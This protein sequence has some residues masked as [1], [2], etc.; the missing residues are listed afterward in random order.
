MRF[1]KAGEVIPRIKK[2]NRESPAWPI[3]AWVLETFD[4]YLKRPPEGYLNLHD[5]NVL[6]DLGIIT[7]K[8]LEAE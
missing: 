3:P 4:E 5:T 2:V 1:L 7:R 8:E 6:F